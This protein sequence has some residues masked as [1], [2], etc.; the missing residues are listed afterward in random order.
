VLSSAVLGT[1]SNKNTGLVRLHPGVIDTVGNEIGFTSQLR[2]PEAVDDI[3]GLQDQVR[4]AGSPVFGAHRDV[5]FIGCDNAKIGILD[6]PPPLVADE[7]DF[8]GILWHRLVLNLHNRARGDENEYENNQTRNDSPSHF[9]V[10][11]PINLWRLLKVVLRPTGA[12]FDQNINE[13][14]NNNG[15]NPKADEEDKVGWLQEQLSGPRLGL[16]N[17]G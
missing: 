9:D 7:S 4:G 14:R 16:E 5:N 6:F 8:D 17:I 12:E 13:D 2:N 10:V 15:K 1:I 11:T 3:G